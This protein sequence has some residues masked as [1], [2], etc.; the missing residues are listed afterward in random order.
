MWIWIQ[1]QLFNSM[2]IGTRIKGVFGSWSDFEIKK[3]NFYVKNVL[4][5]ENSSKTYLQR[6]NSFFERQETR[7]V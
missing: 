4:E 2:W 7:F 3:M 6:Y 5:V 1:M